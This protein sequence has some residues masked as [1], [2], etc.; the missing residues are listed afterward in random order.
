MSVF[1]LTTL[2]SIEKGLLC[3]HMMLNYILSYYL[4]N[5]FSLTP[6]PV[7]VQQ[8]KNVLKLQS[9]TIYMASLLPLK[10]RS[11]EFSLCMEIPVSS[12]SLLVEG[13]SPTHHLLICLVF[14]L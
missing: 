12:E 11:Y 4:K 14:Q 1:L 7:F 5:E 10:S 8:D 2:A 9:F 3:K 13:E 6:S